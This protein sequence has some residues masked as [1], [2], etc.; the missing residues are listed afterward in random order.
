ML[1]GVYVCVQLVCVC[2]CLCVCGSVWVLVCVSV[3][4]W[5]S[6]GVCENRTGNKLL[7]SSFDTPDVNS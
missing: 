4:L 3:C 1:S 6:V 7:H 5:V 2:M